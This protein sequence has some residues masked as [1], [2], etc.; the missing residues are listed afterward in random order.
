MYFRGLAAP[1]KFN[2]FNYLEEQKMAIGGQ[3]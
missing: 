1:Q 3:I 2:D